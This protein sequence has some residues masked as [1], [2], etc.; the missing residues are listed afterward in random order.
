LFVSVVTFAEHFFARIESNIS[1]VD[2]INDNTQ[3]YTPLHSNDSILSLR[4]EAQLPQRSSASAVHVYL[5]WLTDRAM[6]TAQ[7]TAESQRLYYF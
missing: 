1:F 5:D 4:Q 7:N 6:H 3:L 2:K